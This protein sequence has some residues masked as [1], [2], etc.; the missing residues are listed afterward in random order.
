MTLDSNS[1]ALLSF[2]RLV[3]ATYFR[4]HASAFEFPSPVT[5]YHSVTTSNANERHETW[6]HI[7]HK[8]I[9]LRADTE[10]MNVPST[11]ALRLHWRGSLWVI[12]MWNKCIENDIDMPGKFQTEFGNVSEDEETNL[13]MEAV[14]GEDT[15]DDCP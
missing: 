13:I 1:L 12:H 7:I 14:F 11:T 5:L 2:C 8:A 3:G 10:S 4:V 6:L 15:E 9:W